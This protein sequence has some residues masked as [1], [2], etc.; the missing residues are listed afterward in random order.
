MAGN[1]KL[2]SES[3]SDDP[4][5][6]LVQSI[7]DYAIY[8]LD[9][10]GYV[11][12]WN[13]GAERIKGFATE[14]IVG[15]HF[16][17][18]YTPEDQ[19][20]GMPV[21]VLETA[22]R[23]GKFEGEGWRVRK[24]GSRF[25]ASV[26]VDAIKDERGEVIGFAKITRDMTDQRAAQQALLEAERR[27]RILVQGVTD[28]AI[29]MLDPDGRVS[30]WNSGAERIKGYS[31]TEIIGQHFSRFYTP[32]DLD[33]AVPKRALETARSTG[34]YEAEGWRVRK[35]GTRFWASVVI[36]AIRGDDGE[37]IGFA[38]ITRNMTE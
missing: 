18:F 30:N 29:Y 34:R 16:S 32:E 15:K 19:E 36:D 9:P 14:E 10:N 6:L 24:D 38:K 23:E 35:D 4:F 28:Y 8:M 12:S 3:I 22:R 11:T 33:A 13:A 27:F 17:T 31:P 20:A 25:W 7:L 2:A 5:R 37:I 1:L 21:K 26:V